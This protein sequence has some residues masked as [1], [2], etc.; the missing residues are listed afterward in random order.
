MALKMKNKIIR[1]FINY[2]PLFF[3]FLIWFI[4]GSPYFIK[5]KVPYPSTYQVNFF[6]P[7]SSDQTNWGPVK[8]NA[9]PDVIDQIYP[10][11]Y[12]T[13]NTYKSGQIPFWNPNSFAGTPH[14]ANYQSAVLS[15]FNILFFIFPFIDAWSIL[16]LLQPLL[17]GIFTYLFLRELR[18]SKEGSV[19][20]SIAFMFSGFMVVWMAYGTL[21]IT[22]AFLPFALLLIERNFNKINKIS[23]IALSFVIPVAFFSGHFQTAIYFFVFVIAFYIF[24]LIVSKKKKE[25]LFILFSIIV[26]LIIS[27]FQIVPS[28]EFYLNSVRSNIF[29]KGGGIPWFYLVNIF[30]PDFYGNPVTRNDWFGTYAEWASFIG[31][32]PLTLALFGILRRKILPVFFFLSGIIVLILAIDSPVQSFIGFLK[33]PVLSTSNPTRIIVLFS[34]SFA[35]LAGFGLDN[36]KEFIQK[37]RTKEII[38]PLVLIGFIFLIALCSLFIFK[39][40]PADKLLIAKRNIIIPGILF[41]ISCLFILVSSINKKIFLFAICFFLIASSFDSLRFAQKWMPFDPKSSVFPDVPILKEMKKDIGYGRVFGNLGG[42]IDSYY[43]LPSVEGYDPLYIQRFGE[44]TRGAIY[45][46]YLD[47]E[48]SVVRL[49]RRAKYADKVLDLLGVNLIFHPIGDTNTSWAYPVWEKNERYGLIYHDSTFQLFKNKKAL[50]RAVLFNNFEIITKKEDII[51]R[52]YSDSFDFRNKLILEEE[53]GDFVQTSQVR[54]GTA[55]IILYSPDKVQIQ[56][57][58]QSPAI[59]FLSDN[60]YP[61]W[62]AKI[63]SK[64]MKNGIEA[65]IYRADYS[66]RAVIVPKGEHVVEFSYDFIPFP[67]I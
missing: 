10:W 16:I 5:N 66:F 55:E 23:L 40:L 57:K 58:T 51:K 8:N 39:S 43:N 45:G 59:L 15:P 9:M 18:V 1:I 27:A 31:I 17:A 22:M 7:W 36:L 2:W 19:I 54:K 24:K 13:I 30:S 53:P 4:F 20:S 46:T 67:K 34:F 64:D 63:Y 28:I 11:K 35:V 44:F 50:P 38:L 47:A 3:I 14:L 25:G 12:F 6:S 21:S 42:Q 32:I 52:F 62:K 26:G 65:K 33:I 49:D 41:F 61:R 29:I 48:R 60:F 37:K 56:V